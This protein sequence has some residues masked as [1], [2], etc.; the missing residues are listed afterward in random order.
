[1]KQGQPGGS[2]QAQSSGYPFALRLNASSRSPGRLRLRL[3]LRSATSST[4]VSCPLGLLVPLL[5]C[6]RERS[7]SS[8]HSDFVRSASSNDRG[9]PTRARAH[10]RRRPSSSSEHRHRRRLFPLTRLELSTGGGGRGSTLASSATRVRRPAVRTAARRSRRSARSVPTARWRAPHSGRSLAGKIGVCVA[11][12]WRG[13]RTAR[14]V[15]VVTK[16]RSGARGAH[17]LRAR[18]VVV[19]L[20]LVLLS[21]PGLLLERVRLLLLL[22]LGTRLGLGSVR[23]R[24]S[25]AS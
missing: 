7:L 15:R 6:L 18:R 11:H 4:S 3:R 13:R 21:D 8:E 10:A 2:F 12:V 9:A 5:R 16:A 22:L 17:V 24:A 25:E 19:A 20:L 23:G 1:M 14:G